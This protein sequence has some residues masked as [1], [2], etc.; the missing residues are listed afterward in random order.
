ME[1]KV[2]YRFHNSPTLVSV[3]SLISPP[4]SSQLIFVISNSILVFREIIGVYCE[5]N[6]KQMYAVL[7]QY[8]ILFIIY[9]YTDKCTY[10]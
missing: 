2:H 7:K 4:T 5:K 10:N 8:K 6:T 3:L 1:A 9:C